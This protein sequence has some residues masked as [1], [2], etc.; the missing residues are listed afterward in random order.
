[1]FCPYCSFAK[2]AVLES[3]DSEDGEVTRRR[4]ECQ[5]CGKRFTTY[6]RI[7]V[8]DLKVVKKDGSKE[9]FDLAKLKGGITVACEK[10]NISAEEIGKI[11]EDIEMRLLNRKSVEV[12][13]SDIGRMVLTRLK[14][15]D[16]VAY[17]RFA[18]VFLEFKC[19]DEFKQQIQE[20]Q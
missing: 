20:I 5:R 19:V 11:V 4:R 10:R 1:M 18:S 3:R 17:L 15:L 8:I 6:E 12:S 7:E 16:S 14:K 2:S 9:S 13:S